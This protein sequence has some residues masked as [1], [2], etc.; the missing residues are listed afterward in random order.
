VISTK[1]GA[2]ARRRTRAAITTAAA[3]GVI[4]AAT[5]VPAGAASPVPTLPHS[6]ISF[7]QRDFVSASGFDDNEGPV[8]IRVVRNG[9]TIATSTP[10]S[11]QDDP[12]TPVKDGIVEVNHPGGG[13]W[14]GTTPDILPGDEITTTTKNGLTE[15]TTTANVAASLP[16]EDPITHKITVQGTALDAAGHPLPLDQIEQRMV[17]NKDQFDVNGRRTLRAAVGADGTLTIDSA[18]NWTATYTGLDAAD[19]TRALTAETRILWLGTDPAAGNQATIYETAGDGSVV[20]GPATPDCT[21]PFAQSAI[22]GTEIGG[23]PTRLINQS[24]VG[25]SLV[26]SGPYDPANVGAIALTV[27]GVAVPVT[28]GTDTWSGSV[29]AA[30]LPEGLLTARASFTAGGPNS[31]GAPDSTMALVKDTVAPRAPSANL[32][33]GTYVGAQTITLQ[34]DPGAVIRFT[35]DGSTPTASSGVVFGAPFTVTASQ[36]ITAV[37]VDANGNASAP[38]TFA[39]TI[40]GATAVGPAP[41]TQPGVQVKGITVS[42][43]A[44][45]R[46]TLARRISLSRLRS[47]GLRATMQ[48]QEGTNVVRI[49][50]YKARD[51]RR[52]GRAVYVTTRAARAGALRVSLRGRSLLRSLRAGT[53]VMEVRSGQGLASLGSARLV[54]FTV[55]R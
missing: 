42:S 52:T 39:Y 23:A 43:L 10:V 51:G 54:A 31:A 36:T 55:T 3:L 7:P 49:A 25:G 48:V 6:V 50:I 45:S 2:R 19:R 16:V 33:G 34:S 53:Y 37:A 14:V 12:K 32:A 44:V 9:V 30:N 21:A 11:P 1:D 29:P 26:V 35:A 15:G 40:T 20:G 47:Q 27:G 18:G 5:A 4:A 28:L 24:N 46:L 38:S 13:C 22:G 41:I 17:A 8:T